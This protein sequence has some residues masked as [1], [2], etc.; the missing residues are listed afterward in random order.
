MRAMI[1]VVILLKKGRKGTWIIGSVFSE[2]EFLFLRGI[3]SYNSNF[4][5]T[6]VQYLKKD[7]KFFLGNLPI[8]IGELL[9]V[10]FTC[11]PG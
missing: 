11:W 5:T 6:F 4:N 1:S 3:E 8:E 9:P 10:W 7:I 2:F